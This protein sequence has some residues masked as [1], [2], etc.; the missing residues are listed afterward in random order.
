MSSHRIVWYIAFSAAAAAAL[1]LW[2]RR[3]GEL[4]PAPDSASTAELV[5]TMMSRLSQDH[6]MD[7]PDTKE[8]VRK[9]AEL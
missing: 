1:V 5:T 4:D 7:K 8:S 9:V 3:A 6:P 2:V